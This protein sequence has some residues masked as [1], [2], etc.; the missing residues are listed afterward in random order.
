LGALEAAGVVDCLAIKV[1]PRFLL[2]IASFGGSSLDS[3]AYPEFSNLPARKISRPGKWETG[4]IAAK[5]SQT[6]LRI[7]TKASPAKIGNA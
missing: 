1:F 6:T 7:G 2:K 5:R 4:K 3:D